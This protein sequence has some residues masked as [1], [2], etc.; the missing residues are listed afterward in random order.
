MDAV[1]HVH[2]GDA[3][4]EIL[5]DLLLVARLRVHDEP[6]AGSVI[7]ALHAG[8]GF[9]LEEVLGVDHVEPVSGA[10][11]AG[12]VVGGDLVGGDCVS[13]GI[14]AFG[15][16]GVIVRDGFGVVH[17]R[18]DQALNSLR[19]SSEKTQ[20]SPKIS[21]VNTTRVTTVMIE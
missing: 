19:T 3:G 20:S 17:H 13:H 8:A 1:L 4:L 15:V 2:G 7:G 5:L 12:D 16:R 21:M 11:I 14:G 9:L 10:V 6:L 18:T